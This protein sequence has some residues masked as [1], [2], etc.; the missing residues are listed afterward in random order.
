MNYHEEYIKKQMVLAQKGI[1]LEQILKKIKKAH[2]SW[3]ENIKK[4]FSI[5]FSQSLMV[6]LDPDKI[7]SL[8]ECYGILGKAIV[9]RDCLEKVSDDITACCGKGTLKVKCREIDTLHIKMIQEIS[10]IQKMI[11]AI[12]NEKLKDSPN[13]SL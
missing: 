4:N 12:L 13:I 7:P 8:E 3:I 11:W 6:Q 2:P 10:L 1:P 5:A 9:R